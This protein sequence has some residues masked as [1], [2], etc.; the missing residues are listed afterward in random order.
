[1]DRTEVLIVRHGQTEWNIKGIRQCNLD[2]RLTEKRMAQAKALAQRLAREHFTALYSSDL[3]RAVQTAERDRIFKPPFSINEAISQDRERC[4]F[5][6]RL[7]KNPLLYVAAVGRAVG[8]A[9]NLLYPAARSNSE[10][11]APSACVGR[12]FSAPQIVWTRWTRRAGAR[13]GAW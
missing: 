8:R 1:M 7:M 12:R 3:G 13:G 10:R 11:A 9:R 2:R 6:L 4:Q 5:P